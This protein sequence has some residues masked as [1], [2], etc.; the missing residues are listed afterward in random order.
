MTEF[1]TISLL[2]LAASAIVPIFACGGGDK[3]PENPPPGGSVATNSWGQPPPGGTQPPPGGTMPPPGGTQPPPGGTAPPAGSTAG[4]PGLPVDPNL[5]QQILAA[6][7][8]MMGGAPVGLGDPVELGI[9]AAALKY[10]PGMQAEGAITKDTIQQAGHKEMLLTLQGGK[11]YTIIAFSPPGQVTNV[12]LHLLMPPFYNMMAGQDSFK[13][14]TAVIGPNAQALCPMLPMP[15]QYKLDV[16]AM[17]GT[18]AVGV[19]VYAKNK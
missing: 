19:Q 10:A 1:R 4:L 18:G 11:C 2:A 13:D 12:D 14:N 5:M 7:A 16:E 9:K 15:V 3:P 6:G 17:T 8:A